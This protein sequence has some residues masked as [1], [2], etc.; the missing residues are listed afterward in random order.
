MSY[1]GDQQQTNPEDLRTAGGAAYCR[2]LQIEGSSGTGKSSLVNAGMRPMIEQGALW[3]RTGFE[4]WRVLGPMMPG[5]DPLAN[6]ATVVEHGLTPKPVQPDTLARRQRLQTDKRALALDLRDFRH[7]EEEQ[8]AF[9]LIV[10]QFEE[11]FTF[12]EGESCRQFD[13]LLANALQDPECP[14]FLIGTVRA[15]FLDR[16]GQLPSLQ[17]IYN[18]HCK[19]YFLPTISEH[20]LRE[21]IEQPARLAGVNV[22]EVTDAILADACGE[23]GGALPLVEN[24]LLTLWQQR[25]GTLLSGDDYRAAGGIAGML[26][27]QAD[28]L[29]ARIGAE[30]KGGRQAALDLLLRLTQINDE[31]RHSR[32]RISREEA[33][34]EAGERVVQMLSGELGP[35]QSHQKQRGALRLIVV[36]SED[37]RQP[38]SAERASNDSA[39]VG[40]TGEKEK[41]RPAQQRSVDLIHETL[42]RARGKDEKTGKRLGYWPTLYDY[43]GQ[44]RDRELHRGQL[45][46]QAEQWRKSARLWSLVESRRLARSLALPAA[47]ERSVQRRRAFCILEPLCGVD[48]ARIAAGAAR[49]IRRGCRRWWK[50]GLGA[51]RWAVCQAETS[52]VAPARGPTTAAGS[53]FCRALAPASPAGQSAGGRVRRIAHRAGIWGSLSAAAG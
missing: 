19:R 40:T 23:M 10:D 32:R 29:L 27:A 39:K 50:S 24:A 3:A 7:A 21:V 38:E 51:S 17:A 26:I 2:W 53:A 30:V 8:T 37:Q 44:N 11:L 47:A 14:L 16:F 34:P 12:A 25:E 48:S 15:D 9:L 6:L 31:G 42:I 35:D 28:Q 20:G 41:S 52:K 18:S 33:V 4:R 46:F 43:I 22:S 36:T 1:L 45:R 5:K 13:A 49:R